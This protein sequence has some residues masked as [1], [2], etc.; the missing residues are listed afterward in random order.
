MPVAVMA[1][2]M[3]ELAVMVGMPPEDMPPAM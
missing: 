2:D 1:G 3:A